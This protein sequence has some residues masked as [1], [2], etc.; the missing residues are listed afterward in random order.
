MILNDYNNCIKNFKPNSV[1]ELIIHCC[2]HRFGRFM[3]LQKHFNIVWITVFSLTFSHLCYSHEGH[4]VDDITLTKLGYLG[5][6]E[7]T[8]SLGNLGRMILPM[9]NLP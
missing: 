6:V 5:K 4:K 7:F 8:I 1:I 9:F 3:L 2:I